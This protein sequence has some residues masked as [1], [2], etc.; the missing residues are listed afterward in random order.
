MPIR[1]HA[2]SNG[3]I[4]A[5]G[6]NPV[7]NVPRPL[8]PALHH[9]L[10]RMDGVVVQGP[11]DN[12]TSVWVGP[13]SSQPYEIKPGDM[14]AVI[15]VGHVSEVYVFDPDGDDPPTIPE[16]APY[17]VDFTLRDLTFP[18]NVC[19]GGSPA[20]GP[21]IADERLFEY[22]NI[23]IPESQGAYN[24]TF[25]NIGNTGTVE[26]RFPTNDWS[27]IVDIRFANPTDCRALYDVNC[28]DRGV[29]IVQFGGG[30]VSCYMYPVGGIPVLLFGPVA[31]SALDV[32]RMSMRLGVV[33]F[34][35]NDILVAS[36]SPTVINANPFPFTP[37]MTLF[38]RVDEALG[39]NYGR[40][41]LRRWGF[42]ASE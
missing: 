7:Y 11:V 1:W 40:V 42:S 12:L 27:A 21:V 29:E 26:F 9:K 24:E 16:V 37:Q 17:G 35:Q 28:L 20:F 5:Q 33:D 4:I 36:T 2:Y 30:G 23:G 15:P 13:P 41:A 14:S 34:Y 32:W 31:W 6:L 22:N 38:M 10:S 39:I 19:I 8:R 25:F 3:V 18:Y